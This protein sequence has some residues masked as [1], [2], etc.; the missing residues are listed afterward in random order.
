MLV[1]IWPEDEGEPDAIF[2]GRPGGHRGPP[3][4]CKLYTTLHN[5]TT[6]HNL[7][8]ASMATLRCNIFSWSSLDVMITSTRRIA[9]GGWIF[10]APTGFWGANGFCSWDRTCSL[11]FLA[12]GSLAI[13]STR[14]RK[15]SP[16]GRPG[17]HRG[18][19]HPCEH[20]VALSILVVD[21]G[22]GQG[23]QGP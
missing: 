6:L 14:T 19:P 9:I 20:T 1:D 22:A 15:P 5:S 2:L 7:F 11:V 17:G 16:F 23:H 4:P 21:D 12:D 3:H 18:P 10:T 8:L 13:G